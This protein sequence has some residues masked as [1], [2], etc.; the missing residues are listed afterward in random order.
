MLSVTHYCLTGMLSSRYTSAG[1]VVCPSRR[2]TASAANPLEVATPVP[3]RPSQP[4]R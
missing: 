4:H 2:G 1:P 3:T